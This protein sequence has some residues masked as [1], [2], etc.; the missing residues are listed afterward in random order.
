[1]RIVDDEMKRTK[2]N[3]F[4][5]SGPRHGERFK[6]RRTSRENEKPLH[7]LFSPH[8]SSSLSLSLG[9]GCALKRWN[10]TRACFSLAIRPT[11]LVFTYVTSGVISRCSCPSSAIPGGGPVY[12]S[13][14]T[15]LRLRG[16]RVDG[17]WFIGRRL[18]PDDVLIPSR[19]MHRAPSCPRRCA[20]CADG[21]WLDD[22]LDSEML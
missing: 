16:E 6:S 19:I 3:K 21:W 18:A 14:A 15:R 13:L 20:R 22:E 11:K 9:A 7:S 17:Q 8:P 10:A 1:M 2:R 4:P 5:M 12:R